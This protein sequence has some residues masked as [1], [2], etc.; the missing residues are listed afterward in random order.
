[1]KRLGFIVLFAILCCNKDE[2][3]N[4][5]TFLGKLVVKGICMNYV[6]QVN[7]NNF[8]TNILE[9]NWTNEFSEIEYQNVFALKSFCDF[10]ENIEEVDTFSFVIDDNKDILCAVCLAYSPVP[11]KSVSITVIEN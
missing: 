2:I 10:P 3:D 1:M 7:D 9:E 5:E 8:P 4:R 6:I 11:R